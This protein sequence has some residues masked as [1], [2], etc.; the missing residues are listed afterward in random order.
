MFIFAS[1]MFLAGGFTLIQE[2]HIRMDVFYSRWSPKKRAIFDLATFP[3]VAVFMIVIMI[4]GINSVEFALRTGQHSATSWG[5]ILA[6]I[7]ISLLV[8]SLLFFLQIIA[9]LIRDMYTIRGRSLT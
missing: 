9:A 6:P 7:K 5:P 8:A 2:G 3:L 1:Y 4:G